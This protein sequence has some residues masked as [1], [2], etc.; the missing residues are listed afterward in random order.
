MNG[1]WINKMRLSIYIWSAVATFP[2]RSIIYSNFFS[3]R[4]LLYL[5]IFND[6]D[7]LFAELTQFQ[8]TDPNNHVIDRFLPSPLTWLYA[9]QLPTYSYETMR[10][11]Q[12]MYIC[13]VR[14]SYTQNPGFG[15]WLFF[16]VSYHSIQSSLGQ[17]IPLWNFRPILSHL[18]RQKSIFLRGSYS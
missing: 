17:K 12:F 3:G 11:Y 9:L 1:S 7:T 15:S 5:P 8:C 2:S 14:Y 4:F 13:C 16:E 10:W 6:G 18:Q